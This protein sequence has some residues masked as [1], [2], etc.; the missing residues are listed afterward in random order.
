MNPCLESPINTIASSTYLNAN[1]LYNQIVAD[2]AVQS[3]KVYGKSTV[4]SK[5]PTCVLNLLSFIT[6]YSDDSKIQ[7]PTIKYVPPSEPQ[8]AARKAVAIISYQEYYSD[9]KR[10]AT[11]QDRIVKRDRLKKS[12]SIH[13]I[14]IPFLNRS[15][16]SGK[17]G[18]TQ[19]N[20]DGGLSV[21]AKE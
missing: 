11:T 9:W 7:E 2:C 13:S 10:L 15:F 20:H 4:L 12:K 5:S 16:S 18:P 19:R 6:G 8:P 21:E 17:S 1:H 3:R 14:K